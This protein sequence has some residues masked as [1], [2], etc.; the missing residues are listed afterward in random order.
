M[1][2]VS[3]RYFVSMKVI[4]R[5]LGIMPIWYGIFF[6]GP[7]LAEISLRTS[8]FSPV[9]KL[10]SSLLPNIVYAAIETLPVYG[11]CMVIGGIYGIFAQVT[12][13]WI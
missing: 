8:I 5:L 7:L 9:S 3:I 2:P 10:I 13:R 4:T 6:I 12:G 1:Y 11:I